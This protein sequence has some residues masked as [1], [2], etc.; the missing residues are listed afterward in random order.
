MPFVF[1]PAAS[2]DEKK[3][4][5]KK[6]KKE[7]KAKK[8]KT[9]AKS[10]KGEVGRQLLIF[11]GLFSHEFSGYMKGIK[12]ISQHPKQEQGGYWMRIDKE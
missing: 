4:K 10:K 5:V 7:K 12:I 11:S 8:S 3:K 6:V 9:K 2:A 1:Q